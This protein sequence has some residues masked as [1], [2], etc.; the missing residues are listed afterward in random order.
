MNITTA[1]KIAH[2]RETYPFSTPFRERIARPPAKRYPPVTHR[3]SDIVTIPAVPIKSLQT[4]KGIA[5]ALPA[6]RSSGLLPSRVS[7]VPL[8]GSSS[9]L[10][11][12][13]H[14]GRFGESVRFNHRSRDRG[15]PIAERSREVLARC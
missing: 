1:A 5:L 10:R 4:S 14:H 8:F 15:N 2:H 12:R 9:N 7:S 11:L 6:R 3:F 13:N